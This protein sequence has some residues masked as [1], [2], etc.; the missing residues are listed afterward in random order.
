MCD[1]CI[2]VCGVFSG[3]RMLDVDGSCV[4][5]G[6]IMNVRIK[7]L[8]MSMN[9]N[10]DSRSRSFFFRPIRMAYFSEKANLKK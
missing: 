7:N 2:V 10:M 1:V 4:C 5:D 6:S 3:M 9:M 8:H